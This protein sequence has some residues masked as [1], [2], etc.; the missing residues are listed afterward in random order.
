MLRRA[1]RDINFNLYIK[2][3]DA[4]MTMVFSKTTGLDY[5]RLAQYIQ[6]KV[7]E[8]YVH[9]N[10]LAAFREFINKSADAIFHDPQAPQE[11]KIACLMNMTEQNMSEIFSQLNLDEETVITTQKLIQSYVSLMTQKPETLS[12]I[13]KLVSHGEYLYYHS[14]AVSIFSMLIA[15]A[16]GLFDQKMLELIGLGGLLHDIGSTQLP[17]EIICSPYDLTMTQWKH[18]HEHPQLGLHMIEETKSIPKEVQFMIYQHHEQAGGNGYPNKIRGPSIYY[19]AKIVAIADA[20]SALISDRP[21]R[22]AYSIQDSVR[23]IQK[24]PDRYD[25]DLAKILGSIFLRAAPDTSS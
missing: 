24:S 1:T 7:R 4:N 8:L 25:R 2:L 3:S 6:K 17:K 10:D 16:T 19:P 18:M 15:R 22:P 21:F 9:P 14:I 23:M 11:K 13:L 20:F 12:I 5:K